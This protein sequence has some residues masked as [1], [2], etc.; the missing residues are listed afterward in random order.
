VLSLLRS[1]ISVLSNSSGN[2]NV[3]FLIVWNVYCSAVVAYLSSV[4]T[5]A[6][7][8][9]VMCLAHCLFGAT[10]LWVNVPLNLWFD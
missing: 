9:T 10:A 2:R 6:S 8:D 4:E 7:F 3:L 5:F 1:A